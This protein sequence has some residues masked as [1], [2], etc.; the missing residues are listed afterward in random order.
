M[1]AWVEETRGA[2]V[3]E[4]CAQVAAE[5]LAVEAAKAADE[6]VRFAPP[7]FLLESGEG[8]E[9]EEE[10]DVARRLFAP[11]F[12]GAAK[13]ELLK[14]KLKEAEKEQQELIEEALDSAPLMAREETIDYFKKQ[15]LM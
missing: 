7:A 8:E 13:V 3:I 11:L 12:S 4:V 2:R 5:E 14:A 15:R 10:D 1:K 9:E 6:A